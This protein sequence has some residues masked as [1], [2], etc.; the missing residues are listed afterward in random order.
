MIGGLVYNFLP[1]MVLPIYVALER[2]DP[3]AG[4]GGPATCTPTRSPAFRKVVLPLS[5]P[6]VFAGV[7]LTFVPVASDYVNAAIL[8]GTATHDD[9]QHHPDAV[10]D[11]PRTTRR[12]R[13]CRS[14]LMAVLLVGIFAYARVLGTEDV[15][16]VA[17]LMTADRRVTPPERSP[18][19]GGPAADRAVGRRLLPIYTWL[20]IAWLSLP[21]IVM[22]VFGF[23]DTQGKLNIRPGRASPSSGTATCSSIADLTDGAGATRC[24]IALVTTVDRR[25]CS[26]RCMGCAL[27]RYRFRGSGSVNLLLFANIAAP[28]IVLGAVAAVAVPD[29]RR[30]ARLPDDHRSRT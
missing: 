5:L 6:G 12:P 16:E 22:I 1:F 29:A 10:P 11:Q 13:R 8:G 26:A 28:E 3:R 24:S 4:R 7:L 18:R 27:G 15:L 17:A 19:R 25:R 23:N 30:P 2:I 14:S 20:I 9:R 21:I